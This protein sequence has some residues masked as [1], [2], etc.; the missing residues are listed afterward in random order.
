[1]NE[2]QLRVFMDLVLLIR[3][4]YFCE[5]S[6]DMFKAEELIKKIFNEQGKKSQ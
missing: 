2:K 6:S 3:F 1:M 5:A 4:K